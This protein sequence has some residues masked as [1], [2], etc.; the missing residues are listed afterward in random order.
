MSEMETKTPV[1]WTF[2]EVANLNAFQNSH[3]YHPL[4]CGGDRHDEAHKKYQSEHG[5]D[6][7]QL[8]ATPEGWKCPVCDYR[9]D[10]AHYFMK[11]PLP[12]VH[13]HL[14]VPDATFPQTARAGEGTT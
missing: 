1:I 12:P 2:D 10:S 6:F 3:Q 13:P 9:Q 8:I 14:S 11:Q 4:T 5:G 7:G